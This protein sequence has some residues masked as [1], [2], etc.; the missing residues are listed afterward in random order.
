MA[1]YGFELQRNQMVPEINSRA[2]VYRHIK[3]GA[4]LLSLENDDENKVFG[5]SFATPP[6]D[7]TGVPHILEHSV[8][9]GSQKF[10]LKDPFKELRKSSLNT[11]LNAFTM[12]DA[13][14]Y[15]VASQNRRDFYNLV[16][17][18]LD[19]VFHPLLARE[20]FQE[21]GWHYELDKP[22][23][24]LSYRGIVFNEMKGNYSDPDNLLSEYSQRSIFPDTVYRLDSGGD[25]KVIPSL[26]YEQFVSF[27]HRYYQP[28]NAYIVFYGDDHSDD[29]LRML[30]E[31]LKDFAATAPAPEIPLQPRIAEPRRF[32]YP[33]DA[34][35]DGGAAKKGYV[36]INWMLHEASDLE[37]SFAMEILSHALVG[38]AASP[39]RKA[40]IDSKLGEDLAHSGFADNYRQTVFSAGLK[41]IAVED[42][43]KV[44]Q[45]ILETLQKLA[46]EGIERDMILA[47]LNTM[48]FRLREQNTGGFPRGIVHMINAVSVW[49]RGGD[50]LAGI[51]FEAP[52]ANVKASY[53]GDQ[54]YFDRLIET[55]LLQN[56]HRTTIVLK[57]DAQ[58]GQL[59]EAEENERLAKATAAMTAADAQD[60]IA[61]VQHLHERQNAPDAPEALATIPTLA[62]ADLD[63]EVRRIPLEMQTAAGA[64][65]LYH[66][67]FTNG[68]VYLDLGFQSA[69]SSPGVPAICRATGQAVDRHGHE[70]KRLREG[71]ATD[72]PENGRHWRHAVG[73][74]AAPGHGARNVA[75]RAR[76][77][78]N[79]P[80]ARPVEYSARDHPRC[81]ARQSRALPPDCAGRQVAPGSFAHAGWL[82]CRLL[83]LALSLWHSR[84]GRR[85]DGRHR[86]SI[87][88]ASPGRAHRERLA[89]CARR[90]GSR[91]VSAR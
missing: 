56:T 61:S 77:I 45:L 85:A 79:R 90:P 83:A 20:T 54:H 21:E 10:P 68:I 53:A 2:K 81:A 86:L 43:G 44:E 69:L 48:E 82:R 58:V 14:V 15:P 22:D 9:G 50:P 52:L 6:E 41:G 80:C 88:P 59:T 1:I 13:T 84:L 60:V 35:P 17:V 87:L 36:A 25:P 63:T 40:L 27:H 39:L 49:M 37:A 51:S 23:G 74:R 64:T 8:L 62:L 4:R 47:S 29:R 89:V 5:I 72:R 57:P 32:S 67:L 18:Y 78:N 28:A 76:Q 33:Y 19:A 16:T 46:K 91:A 26:T 71:F 24:P 70:N 73:N 66:D 12:P 7:S 55:K 75:H 34:G 38:T 30:D 3:T 42:A 11:F 31:V 65:V